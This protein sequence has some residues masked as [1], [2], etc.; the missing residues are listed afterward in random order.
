MRHLLSLVAL[1]VAATT[2]AAESRISVFGVAP[3][4]GDYGYGVS[5]DHVWSQRLSTSLVVSSEP[6]SVTRLDRSSV[7][8]TPRTHFADVHPVDVLVR[9]HH[10]TSSR[11]RPYAGVG[12]R[13]IRSGST[14]NYRT[15][16]NA[17]LRLALT[18]RLAMEA[19]WKRLY[20][21]RDATEHIRDGQFHEGGTQRTSLGLTWRF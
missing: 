18:G 20:N 17:G 16:V 11:F 5:I 12:G 9:Y 13:F 19:D 10:A 3:S 4:D 7:G 2:M 15:V 1:L 6:T 8:V 21:Q 14:D